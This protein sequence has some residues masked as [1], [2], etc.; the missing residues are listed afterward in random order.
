MKQASSA[1]RREM[2]SLGLGVPAREHFTDEGIFLTY[3]LGGGARIDFEVDNDGECAY[4]YQHGVNMEI[5]DVK[6]R[7]DGTPN[8]EPLRKRAKGLCR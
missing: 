6:F 4:A 2:H 7:A 3:Y 1:I 5:A 8:L